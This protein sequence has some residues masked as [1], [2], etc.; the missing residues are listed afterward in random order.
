MFH[1]TFLNILEFLLGYNWYETSVVDSRKKGHE[2]QY[3][4]I[5]NLLIY[6]SHDK[7]HGRI[8]EKGHSNVLLSVTCDALSKLSSIVPYKLSVY[9]NNNNKCWYSAV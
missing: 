8:A 1:V 3:N 2:V 7:T 6:I 5:R 4:A 9:G